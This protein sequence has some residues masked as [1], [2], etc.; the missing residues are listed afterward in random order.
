MSGQ[1][2]ALTWTE[3]G[4]T[5]TNQRDRKAEPELLPADR[6]AGL[7]QSTKHISA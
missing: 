4:K 6:K 3:S 5:E 1:F 2:R 7:S